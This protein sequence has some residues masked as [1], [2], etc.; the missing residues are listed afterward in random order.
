LSATARRAD[1]TTGGAHRHYEAL[2]PGRLFALSNGYE[3][4]GRVSWHPPEQRGSAPMSVYLL[5]EPD[6]DLLID[7]GLTAHR[8]Q[9]LAGLR[10]LGVGERPLSL[11]AL[12]PG[13]F[14]SICNLAPIVRAFKVTNYYSYH[15]DV[16]FW[17][18]QDPD[19]PFDL[20]HDTTIAAPELVATNSLAAVEIGASGR[21]VDL[22]RPELRLLFTNWLYDSES[23]TLFTSDS[24]S[25]VVREPGQAEA[26]WVVREEEDETSEEDIRAHLVASRYWWVTGANLEPIR[27]QLAELVENLSIDRIAPASGCVL[28]GE[29]LVGKHFALLDAVLAEEEGKPAAAAVQGA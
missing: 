29:S 10:E 13:E 15:P 23:R 18:E 16:L 24:F 25:W 28:E 7:T 26:G 20:E 4:D 12:R 27:A 3:V 17:G 14:D 22:I 19:F 6:E 9:V 11:L 8:E 5:R 2:V 21:A 1:S